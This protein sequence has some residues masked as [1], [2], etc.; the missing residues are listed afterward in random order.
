MSNNLDEKLLSYFQ[1]ENLIDAFNAYEEA[2]T[3]F[4][5][6]PFWQIYLFMWSVKS[7]SYSLMRY[8]SSKL[9]CS[10]DLFQK[11]VKFPWGADG[12]SYETFKRELDLRCKLIS[13]RI[14]KGTYQ[15]Y[16]FRELDIKKPDGKKKM[17]LVK[18][19]SGGKKVSS[20]VTIRSGGKRILSIATIRDVLV[21]KIL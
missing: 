16:P 13:N 3:D 6:I 20:I 1:P 9:R 19:P 7:R 17:L 18:S 14:Q 10:S 12:I 11:T 21:Q 2:K 5:N 4:G 8:I 15:F